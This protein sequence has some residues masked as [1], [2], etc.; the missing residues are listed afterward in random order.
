MGKT[1]INKYITYILSGKLLSG[2]M[3]MLLFI[4]HTITIFVTNTKVNTGIDAL[5]LEKKKIY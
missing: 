4:D 3:K 2:Q 5:F 1:D